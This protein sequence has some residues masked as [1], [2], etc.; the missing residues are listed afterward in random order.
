MRKKL[1]F[2]NMVVVAFWTGAAC[3]AI[4][5]S[6]IADYNIVWSNQ[7]VDAR[8]SMPI[9]GGNIALNVWLEKDELMMYIGSPDS[10]SYRGKGF[11]TQMQTKLGRIRLKLTPVPWAK[12]FQQELE[13]ASNSI[14][15]AGK[16]AD[17]KAVKLRVWID[18]LQPV[19][20][21]EGKS[22]T[23][24]EASVSVEY[25]TGLAMAPHHAGQTYGPLVRE[26]RITGDALEWWERSPTID[27]G[28]VEYIRRF[29]IVKEIADPPNKRVL[30]SCNENEIV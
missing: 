17:N 22:D 1:L 18:A 27:Q 2:I 21:L 6:W 24:V 4:E 30:L 10:W 7:S 9:G 14:L 12:E 23:P 28:R 15:L 11:N 16:T 19:V 25:P 8:G 3:A 26:G 5:P 29:K 20:H 13:L